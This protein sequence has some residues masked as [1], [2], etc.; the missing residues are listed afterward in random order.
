MSIHTSISGDYNITDRSTQQESFL[1]QTG[2]GD[3][4]IGGVPIPV[5]KEK[6]DNPTVIAM[7]QGY[8]NTLSKTE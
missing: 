4:R 3:A 8:V 7:E 1:I 5:L 2:A 6:F